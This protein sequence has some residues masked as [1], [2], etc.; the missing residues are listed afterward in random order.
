[1]GN[2]LA[3][4]RT[5]ANSLR[6]F[7][8][9]LSTIQNNVVNAR[10]PGYARQEL[11]IVALRFDPTQGLSGGIRSAGL[12]SSRDPFTDRLVRRQLE[13]VGYLE[14]MLA[15]R[16]QIEAVFEIGEQAGLPEAL[17]RLFRAFSALVVAPNDI[18]TR[19]VVIERAKA[20]TEQFRYMAS[21]IDQ[22]GI[23]SSRRVRDVI[24][25]INSWAREIAR[26]NTQFRQS[27]H[28]R[29][30]A[31]VEAQ[32]H[33]ALERLAELVDIVALQQPDG[34]WQVFA[35]GE[36][37]LVLG[38]TAYPL[39]AT[40]AGAEV[41][42]LDWEGHV[43]TNKLRQGKLGAL[44]ELHNRVLPQYRQQLD[45]FAQAF[46]DRIN[47]QQLAG[48][49]F[50]GN[51]ATQPL[52]EYDAGSGVARSLRVSTISA[53]QLAAA[54]VNQPGGNGNAVALAALATSEEI[55]GYS[56]TEY[57]G[58]LAARAGR[59]LAQLRTQHERQ[60]MLLAQ[61]REFQQEV[62]GVDLNVEAAA[63]MDYQ[64][65]YEATARLLRVLNELS[66]VVLR[67]LD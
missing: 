54:A 62:S 50:Y 52:F 26:L 9:V 23:D 32:L 44:L 30:D 13:Q 19:Q 42:I 33:T 49:D 39:S 35:G 16:T 37:P 28:A 25:E 65:A 57:Y 55:H 41:Q 45:E 15:G 3:S 66:A 6:T 17:N 27:F 12:V 31:G 58:E 40:L 60:Q 56:F 36:V 11:D 8:K 48:L 7:E 24:T 38:D 4:L 5:A 22:I 18:P 46:A 59:D 2:L 63:L 10:T 20:V 43:V 53:E 47:A 61:A 21:Q 64:R 34:T 51:P 29:E 14:Q 1:M 67:I